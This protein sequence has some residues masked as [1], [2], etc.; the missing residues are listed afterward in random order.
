MP[1]T[2]IGYYKPPL[3]AFVVELSSKDRRSGKELEYLNAIGVWTELVLTTMEVARKHCGTLG[4]LKR[5]LAIAEDAFKGVLEIVSM[6][7]QCFRD[8]TEPG[9][10]IARQM[11]FLVSKG[12]DAVFL[13]SYSSAHDAP[14]AKMETEAA[15]MLAKARLERTSTRHGGGN[16]PVALGG[17]LSQS[18]GPLRGSH[19][20]MTRRD[21]YGKRLH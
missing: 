5:N 21:P 20:L 12:H 9:V 15:K 8:I 7:T 4:D 19:S 10:E 6:W 2:H 1:F 16:G 13:K 3:D 18:D 17:L 11:P 14:T